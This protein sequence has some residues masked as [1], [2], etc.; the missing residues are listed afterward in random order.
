VS[1]FELLSSFLFLGKETQNKNKQS[2]Q[3]DFDHSSAIAFYDLYLCKTPNLDKATAF[4]AAT[5]LT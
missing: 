2:R 4:L 3:G 5:S 1:S